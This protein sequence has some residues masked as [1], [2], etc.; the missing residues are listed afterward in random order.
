[1][2]LNEVTSLIVAPTW[3]SIDNI[4]EEF[5]SFLHTLRSVCLSP[6]PFIFPLPRYIWRIHP[7]EPR[8]LFSSLSS[9][10]SSWPLAINRT[11]LRCTYRWMYNSPRNQ[12]LR[13]IRRSVAGGHRPL[14]DE[15]FT[16]SW[17]REEH[18]RIL[19]ESPDTRNDCLF[20]IEHYH[21]INYKHLSQWL[22]ATNDI[23][24]R[25]NRHSID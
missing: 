13:P 12:L 18:E 20:Q 15:P 16:G 22:E 17:K 11:F 23:P 21:Q 4:V 14:E 5:L 1:M 24:H 8:S 3:S 10:F 7:S 25:T 2:N 9:R 6:F 19:L